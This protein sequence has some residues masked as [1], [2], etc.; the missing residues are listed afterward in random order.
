MKTSFIEQPSSQPD[1]HK[2]AEFGAR[3]LELEEAAQNTPVM[4]LSPLLSTPSVPPSLSPDYRLS[5]RSVGGRRARALALA[6]SLLPRFG[7]GRSLK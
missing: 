1:F 3:S 5:F 6:S 4:A 2:V 7:S